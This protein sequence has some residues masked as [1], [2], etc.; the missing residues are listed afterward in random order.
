MLRFDRLPEPVR[1]GLH[2]G[3][4]VSDLSDMQWTLLTLC[5]VAVAGEFNTGP[6][7]QPMGARR[8]SRV[9]AARQEGRP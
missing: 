7:G 2:R 8:V 5:I 4:R 3:V 1:G 6:G 9:A